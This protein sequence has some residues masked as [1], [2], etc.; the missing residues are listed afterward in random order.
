MGETPPSSTEEVLFM[1]KA[2]SSQDN[3]GEYR[4]PTE[5]AM[6]YIEA[7]LGHKCVPYCPP[8]LVAGNSVMICGPE[9]PYGRLFPTMFVFFRNYYRNEL[10]L[11]S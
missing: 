4:L 1:G 6:D 8:R 9:R 2:R 10:I 7:D 5:Q 11:F 3:R